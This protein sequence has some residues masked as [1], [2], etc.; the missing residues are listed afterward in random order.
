MFK[1]VAVI[2]AGVMGSG[3]AAQIA[4]NNIEVLLYDLE[5]ENGKLVASLAIDKLINSPSSPLTHK[6]V[7]RLIC[8]LS[9]KT[10]LN[11]LKDCDMVIEAIIENLPI[12][13]QFYQEAGKF[14]REDA[15]IASNTSTFQLSQL[16]A[17][18][19]PEISNKLVICHF[20]NPPR[21][22]RLLELVPGTLQTDKL[23]G[24]MNFLTHQI[25]KNVII[26][27][28][29]PGFIANRLGCFLMELILQELIRTKKNI[30]EIDYIFSNFLGFPSTGIFGLYDL[31]G[32]DVMWFITNS[33]KSSLNPEDEFLSFYKIIPEINKMIENGY[34]GRK[35]KGGFYKIELDSNGNKIKY[36]INLSNFEYDEFKPYKLQ[37][38]SLEEFFAS[39]TELSEFISSIL[40][41]FFSYILSI[42]QDIASNIYD[43]DKA[44][45]LGYAWKHGPFELMQKYNLIPSKY[46][47]NFLALQI[48]NS[49]FGIKPKSLNEI[50]SKN[51]LIPIIESSSSKIWH[52][53]PNKICFQI[54]SK[55]NVLSEDIFNNLIKAVDIAES[56]KADLIIYSDS[57][58]F[59]AG[60]DLKTFY[61]YLQNNNIESI[62][63]LLKLGQKVMLKLKYAE[64]P[65]ISCARGVALGG[66]CEILLH[67]DHIIA[68]QDLSAGLVETSVGLIPGWGGLK[69]MILE[70]NDIGAAIHLILS[71][72]KSRSA[73]D[74]A[75]NFNLQ[76]IQS[77]SNIDDLLDI[78]LKSKFKKKDNSRKAVNIKTNLG[79][80]I[81]IYPSEIQNIAKLILS[82]LKGEMEEEDLLKI[83]R[84][85][86]I[87]LIQ[88]DYAKNKLISFI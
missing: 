39:N 53:R 41:R 32:L 4:N 16:K 64:I 86:F 63:A 49:K 67:S 82:R 26:C 59:S 56:Y 37:Y 20:F 19:E 35:G 45:Q 33:L 18:L 66:G 24:L 31:I 40:E 71:H 69:E 65:V 5:N 27:K 85:I 83:E 7:A 60:A 50:I 10:H 8:P 44:M 23:S 36:A 87:E 38:K 43:I 9:L 68:H 79:I 3:I 28:D 15:I 62:G 47:N 81:N 25:G 80:D 1:K 52:L 17:N 30:A 14:L 46:K 55:M 84:E 48:D 54:T 29:Q 70:S 11:A 21:F 61:N 6:S 76:N 13:Q 72:Y 74:F 12:K 77:V 88:T 34:N 57:E 78:A 42:H 75:L 73:L 2:G 22:L 58:H 51:S